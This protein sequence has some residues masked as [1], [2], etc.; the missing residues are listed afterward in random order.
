MKAAELFV[1]CLEEQG[2]EYIFGVPGEENIHLL[3]AINQSS[4]QFIVCRHETGAAFIAGVMGKLTGKPGV[5]LSTLG[6]GATNMVTGV[7]CATLDRMPLIAIT[8][9]T[10][11]A[12][13]HNG[14]HQ[15]VNLINLYSPITKWNTAILDGS[16]IP[17]VVSKAFT[18]A[19]NNLPGAIQIELPSDIASSLVQG[20]PL[21]H[22]PVAKKGVAPEQAIND[23]ASAINEAKF[24]IVIIGSNVV[25]ESAA[26]A[27]LSLI[28][29]LQIPFIETYMAK[30]VVPANHPL[31][32]QTI[33]LPEGDFV[34]Q[35][36]YRADLVITIGYDPIEYG[37]KKWN[38]LQSPIIHINI[39]EHDIDRY[40]PVKA[41]LLGDL[42]VNL[43]S[44]TDQLQQRNEIDPFYR[45]LKETIT[46]DLLIQQ[47]SNNYPLAPQFIIKEIRESLSSDDI[48]LSD[49]GAHK[50]WI[51]RQYEALHPNTCIISNGLASM[52]IGL[53]GAIGA[54][55]ALPDKKVIAVCGDGSFIM[56]LAEFETAIRLKLAIVIMVWIDERYG[57]IEW[58]QKNMLG[59]S[60]NVQ[61][62]NPDLMALANAYGAKGFKVNHAVELKEILQK[63][64]S[65]DGPVLI[66]CPVDCEENFRLTERLKNYK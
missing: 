7:A 30:G 23:V 63:A 52:G 21:Q 47:T 37:A 28:E 25:R 13:Q 6:P 18:L 29:K 9:Q 11:L 66:E 61:F 57:M 54:K 58:E 48:L 16:I 41:T 22:Q 19:L 8:A 39:N 40:Y 12:M 45:N 33:G 64:L 56:S 32:L 24:P 34:N 43:Q 1:K 62:H 14:S 3:D 20:K 10:D 53:P 50:L 49:V 5:C 2:V 38:P 59:H 15:Y 35:A 55:L 42:S 46:N 17:E 44:L 4:I 27:I 60:A 36:F 26:T 65:E 51:G 31:H